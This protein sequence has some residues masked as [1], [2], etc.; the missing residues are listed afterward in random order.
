MMHHMMNM[1]GGMGW[2]MGPLWLLFVLV[3]VLTVVARQAILA[4][5]DRCALLVLVGCTCAP[6]YS[7]YVVRKLSC[8]R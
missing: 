8:V 3:L 5:S 4:V 1:M 2:A 7:R 6:K